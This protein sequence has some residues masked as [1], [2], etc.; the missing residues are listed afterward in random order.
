MYVVLSSGNGP[1]G[2]NF[3]SDP[4]RFLQVRNIL[5]PEGPA[6]LAPPV[7]YDTDRLADYLHARDTAS[8][9]YIKDADIYFSG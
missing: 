5:N 7:I 3:N 8:S 6:V 2:N 1:E 9:K 4:S